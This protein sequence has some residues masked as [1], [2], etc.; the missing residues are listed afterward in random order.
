MFA[1]KVRVDAIRDEDLRMM[2][3]IWREL[4]DLAPVADRL[5]RAFG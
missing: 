2:R 3:W 1:E 5:R 4:E